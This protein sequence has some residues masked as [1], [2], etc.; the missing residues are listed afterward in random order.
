MWTR[1]D[2]ERE[3]QNIAKVFSTTKGEQSINKLAAESARANNLNPEGIRTLVRL[4]N[5][6][7]FNEEF[8]K[9]SGDD[10]ILDFTTG[11][12]EQVIAELQNEAETKVASV[13]RTLSGSSKYD[14]AVDYEIDPVSPLPPM[15]KVAE[16]SPEESRIPRHKAILLLK[17]AADEFTEK[18]RQEEMAWIDLMEKA[19]QSTRVL[20]DVRKADLLEKDALAI[21]GTVLVPELHML[22]KMTGREYTLTSEKVASVIDKHLAVPSRSHRPIITM[23]EKAS[24]TRTKRNENK[25]CLEFVREKLSAVE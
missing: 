9:M 5:V 14:R 22:A 23:L 16:E 17:R 1:K 19:A 18:M 15:E 21:A 4:A 12:P 24:T 8:S 25:K 7:A 2:Y 6:D 20:G 11:D 3:A 13:Q 10:R